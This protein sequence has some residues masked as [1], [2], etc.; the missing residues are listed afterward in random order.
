[1][2][3]S[4]NI[5]KTLYIFAFVPLSLVATGF[6]YFFGALT[7]VIDPHYRLGDRYIEETGKVVGRMRYTGWTLF[8][9]DVSVN[10]MWVIFGLWI[11]VLAWLWFLLG[12]RL[13]R[14]S[15]G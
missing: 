3:K 7:R 8:G 10:T 13:F 15:R 4:S 9:V 2:I 5:L 14:K 12:K 6:A 1:M 11:L